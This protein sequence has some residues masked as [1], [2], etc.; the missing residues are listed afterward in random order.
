ML[1]IDN[2]KPERNIGNSLLGL[3]NLNN[4]SQR[5]LDNLPGLQLH[6]D[7]ERL[8][9]AFFLVPV[10]IAIIHAATN[11]HAPVP[12]SVAVL[13]KRTRRAFERVL[14]PHI[15]TIGEINTCA[16]EMDG[17]KTGKLVKDTAYLVEISNAG[18]A[19]TLAQVL[20]HS[21]KELSAKYRGIAKS[22]A[23]INLAPKNDD[24]LGKVL[25]SIIVSDRFFGAY[26]WFKS[27]KE[28]LFT[29]IQPIPRP[30]GQNIITS[31]IKSI[32]HALMKI[33]QIPATQMARMFAIY[34][35]VKS[36]QAIER[37]TKQ[38]SLTIALM[39]MMDT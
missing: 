9:G 35:I 24:K 36:L 11:H 28:G 21:D 37:S 22:L 3:L 15:M 8:K 27:F 17:P 23:G 12:K 26:L 6:I 25:H 14:G 39:N 2:D 18:I 32:F 29:T 4:L 16:V 7:P 38:R 30:E 1:R 34:K 13:G 5:L 20:A 19:Y 31:K 10:A 33:I